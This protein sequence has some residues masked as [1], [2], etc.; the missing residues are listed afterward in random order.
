MSLKLPLY[1]ICNFFRVLWNT[2]P[3]A[4]WTRLSHYSPG[5]EAVW[6]FP[7]DP[8]SKIGFLEL[9]DL[10]SEAELWMKVQVQEA[11]SP[12]TSP[13]YADFLT[14]P[15]KACGEIDRPH[16][17]CNKLRIDSTRVNSQNAFPLAQKFC[18]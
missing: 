16:D 13:T 8:S 15:R 7:L 11:G 10:D 12:G 14:S 9:K 3:W 17:E 6:P 2:N 1:N 18:L 4:N 5:F